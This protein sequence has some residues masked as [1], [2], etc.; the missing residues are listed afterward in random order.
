MAERY[1]SERTDT[2]ARVSVSAKRFEYAVELAT[3][4]SATSD[5]G[6]EALPYE[7]GVW[8]PEHLLLASLCRCTL[9]SLRH[10]ARQARVELVGRGGA[11]GTVSRRESDGRFAFV[12]VDV[13]LS[14]A[15]EPPPA[16]PEVR[17]LLARA[18][19]DCFVGSSLTTAPAYHW[20]VN[21]EEIA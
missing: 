9:S 13:E 19:R 2:L 11:S 21:G 1:G 15:L 4:W 5:R 18:E 16:Q 14:V 6:G 20:T 7:D 12:R 8:T 3:D 10:H 17:E